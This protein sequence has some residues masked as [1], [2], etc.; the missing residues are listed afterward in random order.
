MEEG[1]ERRRKQQVDIKGFLSETKNIEIS[2]LQGTGSILGPI[3][4]LC[5]INDLP[6]SSLLSSFLFADDTAVLACNANL[7]E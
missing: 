2:V 6:N 4:F 1:K 7:P 3:L 5:F